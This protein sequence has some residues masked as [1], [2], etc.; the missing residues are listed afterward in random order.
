MICGV[1]CL[2]LAN[3]VGKGDEMRRSIWISAISILLAVVVTGAAARALQDRPSAD[4]RQAS[5]GDG[6]EYLVVS[7]GTV[8]LSPSESGSMRK[9]TGAFS[10]ESF[11]LEKNLDKLGAKG[12]E[13][14]SVTGSPADPIFYLKRRK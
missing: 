12:W 4:E 8:N 14:V 10:R 13:L 2:G 9:E 3:I 5:R 7:G 6:W 11:P 1:A